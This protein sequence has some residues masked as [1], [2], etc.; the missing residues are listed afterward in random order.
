MEGGGYDTQ[1]GRGLT[2]HRPSGGCVEGGVGDP[3]SPPY[4]LYCLPR[5]PTQIPVGLQ[6]KDR[7]PRDQTV[8]SVNSH[9]IGGPVHDISRPSQGVC[10]VPAQYGLF[11]L[12]IWYVVKNLY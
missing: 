11:A 7:I 4:H 1:G 8:P 10:H 9:E 3:Q 6:C 2:R 12:I 5:R